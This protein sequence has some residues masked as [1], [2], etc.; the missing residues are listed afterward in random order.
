MVIL[1]EQSMSI[2]PYILAARP[3]TLPA[4]IV[5]VWLGCVLAYYLTSSYDG[6]IAFYTLMGAIWIQIGTNFFNDAIDADKGADTE[7]RLGPKRATA[8]GLISRCGVYTS[9]L[10]CLL[11]ASI[12]GWLL[13][14]ERGWTVIAIGIPS[15]YLCYGY[16]GG[17]WPLAYKGLGELFVVLF[18]GL[19]AVAGT[20]FMQLGEWRPEAILLGMQAGLLSAVLISINNLRDRDEDAGN[21]KRTVAV[22]LGEKKA[23][24]ILM[25]ELF[26]PALLGF[27][28]V[29]IGHDLWLSLIPLIYLI[30]AIPIAKGV[31][32]Q[33]PSVLYNKYL[34]LG[35]LQLIL[36]GVAFHLAAL[37]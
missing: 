17:P 1:D 26:L 32:S 3:K 6:W 16:T 24:L 19:L 12:F 20:V 36:Y 15:L 2:S 31:N 9:A 21:N 7:H 35:G 33:P 29:W 30:L 4:A 11:I 23:K 34:G 13:F 22:I 5:P 25:V 8:S 37:L 10:V 28:W 14:L 18:F 27:I